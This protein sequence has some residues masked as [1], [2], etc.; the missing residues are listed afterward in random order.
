MHK[1]NKHTWNRKRFEDWK[2]VNEIPV[3]ETSPNESFSENGEGDDSCDWKWA[4][5]CVED[6][7]SDDDDDEE[8]EEELGEE[9]NKRRG[10]D[11][12]IG[13]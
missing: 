9:E 7:E 11:K 13:K 2:F 4:K 5:K 8:G 12:I 6:C 1:R 3:P 10:G